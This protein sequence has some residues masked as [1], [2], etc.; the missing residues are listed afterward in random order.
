MKITEMNREQLRDHM[1]AARLINRFDSFEP[2][3]KHAFTLA[4]KSGLENMDMNC[5]SCIRT[6]MEWIQK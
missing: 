1:R 3:W 4:K 2:E 5:S 6:V